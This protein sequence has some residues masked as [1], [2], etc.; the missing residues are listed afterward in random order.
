MHGIRGEDLVGVE[1]QDDAR[2]RDHGAGMAEQ[3]ELA[4]PLVEFVGRVVD[5]GDFGISAADRAAV[6]RRAL[7]GDDD[8][9][10]EAARDRKEPL[11]DPR[12]VADRRDHDDANGLWGRH[13][14][15]IRRHERNGNGATGLRRPNRPSKLVR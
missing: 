4:I 8:L 2:R 11:E 15:T 14:S 3:Q 10:R 5:D 12:L 9:V 13:G 6:V 1:R 7:V